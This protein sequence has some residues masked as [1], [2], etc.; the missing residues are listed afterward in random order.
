MDQ[1][2]AKAR[3]ESLVAEI[4]RHN[5][6]YYDL[7]RPQI[8]DEGYDRLVRELA[9]LEQRFPQLA[10]PDS[11]LR[12]IGG[13]PLEN[14][15]KHRHRTPMMSLANAFSRQELEDFDARARKGLGLSPDAELTY[16]LE[17]K[18]DGLALEL[19]Y[20]NGL[21][22]RAATRGDGEIGELVT[23]NVRTIRDVPLALKPQGEDLFAR[24]PPAYLNVRGE[25][26]LDRRGFERINRERAA[27]EE[28]L[29][30]N[31]RN[32]AAGSIRQLDPAIAA[33]RPLRFYAYAFGGAEGLEVRSQWEW[34]T[35]LRAFGFKT[36][37]LIRRAAGVEE[38][39]QA[40]EAFIARRET[41][42]FDI[43]GMVAKVDDFERQRILGEV[44]KYP[45]WA[46][47][48]KF[49]A[50]EKLTRILDIQVQ[51]GRTGALTPVAIL[52]PVQVSGVEVSRATL[53][54]QDEI[55]RKD[56]RIGDSVFVRRAGEVIPEVVAVVKEAR[57][58]AER[59]FK[60]P[61]ECPACGAD[62][63][64]EEGEVVARCPNR[65]CPAQV[66]ESIVHF[67][68]K[69][70]MDIEGLGP[71]T[72]STLID[73]G[74]VRRVADLYRLD[75]ETLAAQER[76]AEKSAQNL[77]QAIEA[78]K[79][80]PLDKLIFALGVRHVGEHLAEV[81][82]RA[83]G[84]LDALAKADEA[85]LTAVFEVGPEVAGS[86]RLFFGEPK[87][88][89]LIQALFAAG[90]RP[91]PPAAQTGEDPFFAGKTFVVTGAL[92]FASRP[93]AEAM[94][95]AKGGRT[96][97]SVSKKTDCVVAGEAAGS[98]L[99]KA[100]ELGVAIIDEDE[101]KQRLGRR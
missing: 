54:N 57:R 72:V 19:E 9:D 93:E 70:A 69:G 60:L 100:Q 71:K 101:L 41:L 31:P 20:E 84:S 10:R 33:R 67:A 2:Q 95:K 85:G 90:V 94:I 56:V 58:G 24:R 6:Y 83:F 87:N 62:V 26:F 12:R 11:P 5:H 49:P 75:A 99:K 3:I 59:P 66:K 88:R 79:T 40:Y 80:R 92:A 78:S 1:R 44:S 61:K 38:I 8:D 34:L 22:V 13:K 21:L 28:P 64:R 14:F 16:V 17:P 97:G 50:Q 37:D 96:A 15:E 65:D 4:E 43:D 48:Y 39:Q 46:I 27:A 53:H 18:L 23:Q 51:V 45:R 35:L 42:P 52:E 77:V 68:S 86:I 89:E 30:A 98:K 55:D 91:A 29:F 81:L 76:L 36:S 73:A 25:V 32:A 63:V 74:L 47:A 82:A 7:D